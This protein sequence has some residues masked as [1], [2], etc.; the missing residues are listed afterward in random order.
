M[1]EALRMPSD[2][3]VVSETLPKRLDGNIRDPTPYYMLMLDRVRELAEEFDILH[4]HIDQFHFPLFRQIDLKFSL[5]IIGH[6]LSVSD[7]I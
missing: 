2:S 1:E 3:K 7:Q 6:G 4:F 5:F